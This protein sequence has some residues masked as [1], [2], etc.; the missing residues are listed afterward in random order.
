MYRKMLVPLDGSR[1]SEIVFPYAKDL[2][3][4]LGLDIILLHV[5]SSKESETMPLHQAY[6]E[7]KAQIIKRQLR[8]WQKKIGGRLEARKLQ[9]R[10]ELARG[11]PPEE[12]ICYAEENKVD[13]ILMA[14]HGRS[15]VRRWVLGSV[16][17]KIL[18][19]SGIPVWL[20][21]ASTAESV[22]YDKWPQRTLLVPLDGSVLAEKVLP[23]VEVLAK[24]PG[25]PAV[26]VVLLRVDEP[27]T[28]SGQYFRNI[29]ESR[30]EI[31]H[32]LAN[33]E[34]RLKKSK[35]KVQSKVSSGDPAEQIISHG[36]EN[37]FS[38]IVMSTHGHSGM[39]RWFYGSVATKVLEHASNPIF[40]VRPR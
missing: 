36:Q 9:V 7:Y 10:G 33:I 8:E 31:E 6:I 1:L 14:T 15:G 11:Y 27:P 37:P 25:T 40:L 26:D 13:L 4:R 38:I 2:A 18:C 24:Q 34:T 29:P 19:V 16:A 12:I 20:I 22:T 30:E 28:T 23:H 32:Y 17:D 3:A 21:R 5:H 39:S 35:I